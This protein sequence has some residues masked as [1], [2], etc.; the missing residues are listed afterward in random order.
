MNRASEVVL[1]H[2][3]NGAIYF[4]WY[5]FKIFWWNYFE[6]TYLRDVIYWNAYSP[7]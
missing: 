1:W 3:N 5:I 6:T 2:Y 7:L 4:L